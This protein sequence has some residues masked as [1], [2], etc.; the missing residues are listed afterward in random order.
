[1][2]ADGID[3]EKYRKPSTTFRV[4]RAAGKAKS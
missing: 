2:A 4:L 3:V 1:M